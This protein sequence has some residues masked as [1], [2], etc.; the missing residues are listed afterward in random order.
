[1]AYDVRAM[2][3]DDLALALGWAADEGWNPGLGDAAAFLATDPGGFH[4]GSVDGEPVSSISLVR[5][6]EA[7]AFLGLYIVRPE[8]RGTGLGLALWQRALGALPADVVVGLD[9]VPAQQD[10]YRR[11]G[12]EL[13][14]RN[15]RWGGSVSW[16]P[17]GSGPVRDLRAD[18]LPLVASY[19]ADVFP[20][21]RDAFLAAWL[22]GPGERRTVGHVED[23]RLLGFGTIRA[24][25][26]GW[27]VGPLVA[28]SPAVAESLM[29]ALVAPVAPGPVFVDVPEP[30]AAAVDLAGRMGLVPAFETARMYRGPA[31]D[32]PLHRIFGITTLELG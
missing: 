10:S 19:D 12:F 3:P 21:A 24:C 11:S 23:G 1:M 5:Y 26:E 29:G 31:P 8:H 32:L 2:G 17:D 28:D 22:A 16:V 14:H 20:A 15:A 18:D 6:G 25:R 9:G 7:F 30:N 4:V 27:K 13:A